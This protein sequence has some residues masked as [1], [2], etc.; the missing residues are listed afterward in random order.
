MKKVPRSLEAKLC[1]QSIVIDKLGPE[2]YA[3]D[4]ARNKTT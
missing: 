1:P 2:V 3:N 4:G